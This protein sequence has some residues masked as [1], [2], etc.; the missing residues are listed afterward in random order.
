MKRLAAIDKFRGF[1]ILLMILANY[2]NNVI[3]SFVQCR[4]VH[5]EHGHDFLDSIK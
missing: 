4:V 5:P 1:A 3:V 2:M